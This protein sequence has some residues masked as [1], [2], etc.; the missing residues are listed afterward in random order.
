MILSSETVL[1][2]RL[3]SQGVEQ[4]DC[5]GFAAVLFGMLKAE[6]SCLLIILSRSTYKRKT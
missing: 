6:L 3:K 4:P 1:D 2:P 5:D